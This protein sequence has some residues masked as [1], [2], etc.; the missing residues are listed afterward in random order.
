MTVTVSVL[1]LGDAVRVE[2]VPDPQAPERAKRRSY[3]GKP[4]AAPQIPQP[5]CVSEG[6]MCRLTVHRH[7]RVRGPAWQRDELYLPRTI[8]VA[9]GL[10]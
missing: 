9:G 4:Y 5:S 6:P 2:E 1:P 8:G 3:I 10:S 7:Q